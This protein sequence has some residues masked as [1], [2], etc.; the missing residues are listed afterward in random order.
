MSANSRKGYRGERPVELVLR[1]L[2]AGAYRP[3]AGQQRDVGDIAGLPLVV[4]VKNH[5][6]MELSTWVDEMVGMVANAGVETG[7]VW[8]HRR[9]KGNPL[10][11]YVTTNG[12]LF[13]PLLT[14]WLDRPC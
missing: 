2:I 11:W 3:R 1:E 14:A 12:H 7:V 5:K 6:A 4:S 8:H 9:R 10:D 13:M